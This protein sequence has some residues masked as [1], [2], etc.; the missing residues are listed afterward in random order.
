MTSGALLAFFG[1][2]PFV[3][4]AGAGLLFN[5]LWTYQSR[6]N[7]RE[8]ARYG[9]VLSL[10]VLLFE[11]FRWEYDW[12]FT[13]ASVPLVLAPFPGKFVFNDIRP[14]RS[15]VLGVV[16]QSLTLLALWRVAGTTAGWMRW[17]YLIL[18]GAMVGGAC[19]W[20]TSACLMRNVV[21]ESGEIRDGLLLS[22]KRTFRDGR[23]EF[24]TFSGGLLTHG[25]RSFPNG[26]FEDGLFEG[27]KLKDG[28]CRSSS[29]GGVFLCTIRDK[30][31]QGPGRLDGQNGNFKDGEFGKNAVFLS[32]HASWIDADGSYE[33]GIYRNGLFTGSAKSISSNGAWEGHVEDGILH[34]GWVQYA[35]GSTAQGIF[36]EDGLL[37]VGRAQ[38]ATGEIHEGWFAGGRLNG[39][40]RIVS[41][42]DRTVLTGRFV[43]GNVTQPLPYSLDEDEAYQE[44]TDGGARPADG[45]EREQTATWADL[46]SRLAEVS[47]I[48]PDLRGII[49][50]FVRE[51][52]RLQKTTTVTLAVVGEFNSGKSTFVNSLLGSNVA[53]TANEECTAV[54]LVLKSG[55]EIRY[56][57]VSRD[58][59]REPLSVADAERLQVAGSDYV[60]LEAEGPFP[61]LEQYGIELIDT[62]GVSSKTEGREKITLEAIGQADGCF[63]L[64]DSA[65]DG[66]KSFREFVNKVRAIQPRLYFFISRADM[67]S[68]EE[69]EEHRTCTVPRLAKDYNVPVQHVSFVGLRSRPGILTP[70]DA[71][72]SI[73]QAL[74]ADRESIQKERRRAF[75]DELREAVK[76]RLVALETT[77]LHALDVARER[78]DD[79]PQIWRRW[80]DALF[81]IDWGKARNDFENLVTPIANS[82][83]AEGDEKISG[84]VGS[85]LFLVEQSD[86]EK[87]VS[88]VDGSVQKLAGELSRQIQSFVADKIAVGKEEESRVLGYLRSKGLPAQRPDKMFGLPGWNYKAVDLD[89]VSQMRAFLNANILGPAFS[90]IVERLEKSEFVTSGRGLIRGAVVAVEGHPVLALIGAGISVAHGQQKKRELIAAAQTQLRRA[91]TQSWSGCVEAIT[92]I[93]LV[94]QWAFDKMNR[95][96]RTQHG[97][98]FQTEFAL[99]RQ[100]KRQAQSALTIIQGALAC[101]GAFGEGPDAPRQRRAL[102][103]PR[104]AASDRKVLRLSNVAVGKRSLAGSGRESGFLK[105]RLRVWP[106]P[107]AI[108]VILLLLFAGGWVFFATRSPVA[109]PAAAV[110]VSPPDTAFVTPAQTP[111]AVGTSIQDVRHQRVKTAK[112]KPKRALRKDED[113]G[114]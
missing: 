90:G 10:E 49:E 42:A 53:R 85:I 109:A 107:F 73:S 46:R 66:S 36:G 101:L 74:L 40:G 33:K 16:L 88:V 22:G 11:I 103:A 80:R 34:S 79:F 32:G 87:V 1:N 91:C 5:T 37:E 23:V 59:Q 84:I 65:Q 24:G 98:L 12:I 26:D 112:L 94:T 89:E 99:A 43:D 52:D 108:A 76:P 28:K 25:R 95:L 29:A 96:L 18:D 68:E 114:F 3:L 20:T 45:V 78:T 77:A 4:L 56:S 62:P 111:Q 21:A 39:L 64:M 55:R 97:D 72:Q 15:L 86:V 6:A 71:L 51:M 13:L 110:Q 63:V 7:I 44:R 60:R 8:A 106:R 9:I 92:A 105:G 19:L 75:E 50:R 113:L 48:A 30:A 2:R 102:A 69:L 104:T 27:N 81:R 61:L 82:I 38:L 58:G 57:G 14:R 41:D 100:A 67:R 17:M 31:I 35:D 70:G 93:P 54:P 47:N 83:I